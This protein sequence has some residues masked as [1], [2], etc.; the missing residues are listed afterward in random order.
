MS[1]KIQIENDP[2]EKSASQ[3]KVKQEAAADKDG[4]ICDRMGRN[5]LT[6]IISYLLPVVCAGKLG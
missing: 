6:S 4:F 3:Q 2:A 1:C 5:L